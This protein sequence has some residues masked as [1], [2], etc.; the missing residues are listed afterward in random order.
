MLMH[1][2][3]VRCNRRVKN[4]YPLWW[5][6]SRFAPRR[7]EDARRHRQRNKPPPKNLTTRFFAIN[8]EYHL[9]TVS[10]QQMPSGQHET[11]DTLMRHLVTQ[12]R[13]MHTRAER[14]RLAPFPP[15][16]IQW[17]FHRR[18]RQQQILPVYLGAFAHMRIYIAPCDLGTRRK[19][20]LGHPQVGSKR[21]CKQPILKS[22]CVSSHNSC[23]SPV[24]SYS[25]SMIVHQ[26]DTSPCTSM[27]CLS[28]CLTIRS[29]RSVFSAFSARRPSSSPDAM[30]AS[31]T[32]RLR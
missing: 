17:P 9:L 12:Q 4:P 30:I 26:R 31:V 15:G 18:S 8:L 13:E 10:H 32:S 29:T 14:C 1:N 20:P 16:A 23:S 22:I 27:C 24:F 25:F 19:K 28:S 5:R 7:D 2:W 21:I 3:N 6:S 11:V